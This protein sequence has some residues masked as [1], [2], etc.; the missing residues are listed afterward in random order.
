VGADVTATLGRT[1]AARM[2]ADLRA[3]IDELARRTSAKKVGVIGFC[4][5]G[6]MTWQLLAAGE[7]RLAAAAPF[8]GPTPQNHDFGGSRAAVLAVYGEL[9][10]GVNAGRDVAVQSLQAAGLAYDVKVYPGAGHAF[11]NDTGGSYNPAAAM[12]A[13][14]DVLAWFAKYLV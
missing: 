8:Y 9:D 10:S 2:I 5:G 6:G 7:P 12:Q 14:A 1:P 4:F 11:F 3:G 13:Y